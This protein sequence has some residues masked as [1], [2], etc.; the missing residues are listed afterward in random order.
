MYVPNY[1]PPQVEIPGNVAL[2]KWDVQ[3]LF[4]RR[5]TTWHLLSVCVVATLV[6]IPGPTLALSPALWVLFF[7][8]LGLDILR[9]TTRRTPWDLRISVAA[10]PATLII[11]SLV[12]RALQSQGY[13]VWAPMVGVIAASLYTFLCRRDFSFM[14][15]YL[16]SLIASGVTIAAIAITFGFSVGRASWA[17]GA[18]ALYLSFYCYDLASL[19]SRRRLGEEAAATVDLYRDVLN[20][21][22]WTLRCARHWKRHKIWTL[23]WA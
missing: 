13:P 14:G 1:I 16:L 12:M 15:Q 8:I 4:L 23:P 17:L 10:L 21:F 22:G 7:T 11:V 19:M 20:V 3:L 18:D 2:E 9:I 5:V 6:A